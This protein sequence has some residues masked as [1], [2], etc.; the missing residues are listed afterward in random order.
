MTT[1]LTIPCIKVCV[2]TSYTDHEGGEG[3]KEG[4]GEGEREGGKGEREGG[5]GEREGGREGGKRGREGGR[6]GGH[7]LGMRLVWSRLTIA[8]WGCSKYHR[9]TFPL[10]GGVGASLAPC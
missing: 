1:S 3:E 10:Q 2:K 5:E 4:G 8:W 9:G 7:G 6:R